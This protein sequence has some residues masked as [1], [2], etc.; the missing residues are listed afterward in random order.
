MTVPPLYGW[1]AI[2]VLLLLVALAAVVFFFVT[3]SG[4]NAN[5]RSEWQAF[6]AARSTTTEEGDVDR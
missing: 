4:S 6:L 5:Q 3:A 2:L 1:E